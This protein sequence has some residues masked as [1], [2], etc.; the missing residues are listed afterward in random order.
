LFTDD[1]QKIFESIASGE[2][3]ISGLCF[4]PPNKGL[5]LINI[6]SFYFFIVVKGS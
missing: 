2:F 6:F 5:R 4:A 3:N 1:D